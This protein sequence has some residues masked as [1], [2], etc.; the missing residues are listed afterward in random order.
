MSEDSKELNEK[1]ESGTE[2]ESISP[3][4]KAGVSPAMKMAAVATIVILLIAVPM[5]YFILQDDEDGDDDEDAIEFS[6]AL[7]GKGGEEEVVNLHGLGAD[8]LH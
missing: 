8:G 5:G 2:S 7:L 6:V 4:K 3:P 1:N